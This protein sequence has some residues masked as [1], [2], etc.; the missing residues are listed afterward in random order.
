MKRTRPLFFMYVCCVRVGACVCVSLYLT[1]CPQVLSDINSN[2]FFSLSLYL[3]HATFML[4]IF[5]SSLKN[6]VLSVRNNLGV[7]SFWVNCLSLSDL[8]LIPAPANGPCWFSI[9]CTLLVL[10]EMAVPL[11]IHCVDYAPG[12]P[13]V[14]VTFSLPP[15]HSSLCHS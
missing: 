13:S 11:P 5:C 1:V 14:R 9:V 6:Y 2:V 4:F 8:T 10:L 12:F 3:P 15:T 7:F